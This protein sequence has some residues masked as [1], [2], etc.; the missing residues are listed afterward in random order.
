MENLRKLNDND[1][2]LLL[3][4]INSYIEKIDF[5]LKNRK[6]YFLDSVFNKS[7]ID[8]FEKDRENLLDLREKIFLIDISSEQS[9]R[10][11]L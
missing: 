2:A 7:I 8:D 11:L 10:D 1:K 3:S 5:I 9:S 6:Y 4:C